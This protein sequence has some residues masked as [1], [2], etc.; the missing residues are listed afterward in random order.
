MLG[1]PVVRAKNTETSVRAAALGWAACRALAERAR[2]AVSC[3]APRRS[4]SPGAAPSRAESG[5]LPGTARWS[6]RVTGYDGPGARARG[7]GLGAGGEGV[8]G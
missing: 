1:I 5:T 7:S 6:G 3:Q 8:T 4:S 2:P